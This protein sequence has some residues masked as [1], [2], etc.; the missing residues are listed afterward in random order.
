PDMPPPDVVIWPETAVN[1]LLEQSGTAPQDIAAYVGAPVVLGIQ[2]VEGSR[3]FNSLA[4]FSAQGIGPV[5]D[6]FHLVP[7]GEYTP[8]GDVMARFGIRAFAAQH[9]FG[10]SAGPGPQVMRLPGLPPMQ[11]LICYEAVFSHHLIAGEDR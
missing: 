6:K 8:W 10:Y 9:G 1:F 4:E 2:R 7:F 11:P 5:Y 3:Y